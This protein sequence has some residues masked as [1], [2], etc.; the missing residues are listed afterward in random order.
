MTEPAQKRAKNVGTVVI[1]MFGGGV[2][3]GGVVEI[4]KREVAKLENRGVEVTIKKI[5]VRDATKKRDYELPTGCSY[6]T[7]YDD[8]LVIIDFR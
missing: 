5:C 4:L 7:N 2:V 8:I 6:V 3:G 1:G